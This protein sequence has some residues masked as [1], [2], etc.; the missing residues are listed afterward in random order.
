MHPKAALW[1][2]L[3]ITGAAGLIRDAEGGLDTPVRGEVTRF[4]GGERQRLRL[5]RAVLRRPRGRGE[6]V[7]EIVLELVEGSLSLL[8]S[9]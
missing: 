6:S 5:A 9:G 4:S 1:R 2:A 7:L 8:G 3:E